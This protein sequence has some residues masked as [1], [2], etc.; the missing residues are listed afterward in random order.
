MLGLAFFPFIVSIV[1]SGNSEQNLSFIKPIIQF[2]VQ[3][4]EHTNSLLKQK[5]FK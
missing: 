1:L 2:Q 3:N 5:N 4:F